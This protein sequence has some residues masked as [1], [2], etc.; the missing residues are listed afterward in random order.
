[1]TQRLEILIGDEF[2]N[3]TGQ[4]PNYDATDDD[5]RIQLRAQKHTD[6]RSFQQEDVTARVTM[7]LLD[8]ISMGDMNLKTMSDLDGSTIILRGEQWSSGVVGR[9]S[10]R[11]DWLGITLSCTT[12]SNIT[13]SVLRT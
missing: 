1:M 4:F 12:G 9:Q 3:D 13:Q 7:G 10:D 2:D 6:I 5:Q 11:N 8:L